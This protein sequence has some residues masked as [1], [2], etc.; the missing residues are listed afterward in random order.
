M[1]DSRGALHVRPLALGC[2][3]QADTA[4]LDGG[5]ADPALDARPYDVTAAST[6][7]QTI[8]SVIILPSGMTREPPADQPHGLAKPIPLSPEQHIPEEL[9]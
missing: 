7:T 3:A 9:W 2:N 8:S 1:S 5:R 6:W 4:S